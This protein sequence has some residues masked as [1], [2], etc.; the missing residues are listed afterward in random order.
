M[1]CLIAFRSRYVKINAEVREVKKNK[2]IQIQMTE[3]TQT[4]NS[5]TYDVIELSIG[6]KIIGKVLVY[7]EK[8]FQAFM[9]EENIGSSKTMDLAIESIIRQWNLHE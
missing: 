1:F 2:D 9:D 5:E 3:T 6:K 7:G 8:D 4:I